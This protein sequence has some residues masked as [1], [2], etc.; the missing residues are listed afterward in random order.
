MLRK[1]FATLAF[2]LAL[3][4]FNSLAFAAGGGSIPKFNPKGVSGWAGVGFA[5]FTVKSPENGYKLDRGTSIILGGEKGFN[6]MNLYLTFGFSYL[7]TAGQSQ[8]A[9]ST[10]SGE[11]YTAT[12]TNFKA[13]L[14]Q[15]SLGLKFKII[16]TGWFKPYAEGGGM[17]GYY[18]MK[19]DFNGTQRAALDSVGTNYKKEDAIIDMGHY[20]EGGLEVLFSDSF[21]LK[22]AA[23]LIRGETKDV[24]T[25]NKE[26]IKYEAEVFYLSLLKSF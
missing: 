15:A 20:L 6:A 9:Y 1:I 21:G 25:L 8:Y 11:N 7:T 13:E 14:F 17:F 2:F 10:L 24:E 4:M 16:D 12:D 26:K 22:A 23:R 3:C 5:N 18:S 19:Y